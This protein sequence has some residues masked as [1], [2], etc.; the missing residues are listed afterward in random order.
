MPSPVKG[1]RKVKTAQNLLNA[2][3][4]LR[5]KAAEKTRK[6]AEKA[7]EK[8]RKNAKKA[9]TQKKKAEAAQK[10]QNKLNAAAS[11]GVSNMFAIA[12][13]NAKKAAANARKATANARKA[14][15]AEKRAL[16]Q[17]KK[18]MKA[19][20]HKNYRNNYWNAAD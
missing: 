15:A 11:F 8:E 7:A 10:K 14:A 1:T 20:Q 18:N 4:Q 19:R 13:K 6:N 2:A 3:E 17:T 16:A 9:A 5:L 12:N